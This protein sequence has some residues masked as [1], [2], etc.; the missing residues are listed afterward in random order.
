MTV[1]ADDD[2]QTQPDHRRELGVVVLLI[3]LGGGGALLAG[4][5]VWLRLSVSRPAPF[6]ALSVAVRGRTELAALAGFAVVVLLA[7]LLVLVTGRWA[8]TALGVL[9][10]L[11]GVMIGRYSVA[12][13]GTPDAARLRELLGGANKAG[14]G[15]VAIR[16]AAI[17]PALSLGAAV[18]TVLGGLL[19]VTRCRAWS[20]GL[21]SRYDA[22]VE[23]VKSDDPWRQLDRGDDPTIADR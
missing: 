16:H 10:V 15:A 11:A 18:V 4:D 21:S 3:L 19:V 17:W 7:G 5:R 20:P 8:R 6:G 13:F 22:P 9:L 1:S 12:G 2:Q 14:T 23:T